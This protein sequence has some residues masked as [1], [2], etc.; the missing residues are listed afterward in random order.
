M[1][2]HSIRDY[3]QKKYISENVDYSEGQGISTELFKR[4]EHADQILTEG[5][6]ILKGA[7]PPQGEISAIG[8]AHIDYAWLW[9]ISETKRKIP[10][11]FSNAISM[12]QRYENFV[13]AQSSAQMYKDILELY[14]KQLQSIKELVQQ[15]KWEPVGG[16]W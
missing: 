14:P 6:T 12:C 5:L 15:G 11:T 1:D 7:F 4:I 13:F 16:A 8:H 9:P 2:N 10:R 3:I